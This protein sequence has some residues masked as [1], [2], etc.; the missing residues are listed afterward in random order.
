M[1]SVNHQRRGVERSH[2]TAVISLWQ[3]E[4]LTNC[5]HQEDGHH[6]EDWTTAA[7]EALAISEW[8]RSF[9]HNKTAEGSHLKKPSSTWNRPRQKNLIKEQLNQKSKDMPPR[10][11]HHGVNDLAVLKLYHCNNVTII[12]RQHRNRNRNRKHQLRH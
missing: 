2:H 11:M 9:P 12:R 6:R 10:R 7:E 1:V 8:S 4:G 5:R 3:D